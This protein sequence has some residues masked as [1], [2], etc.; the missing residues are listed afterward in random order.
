MFEWSSEYDSENA[1][2]VG[3]IIKNDGKFKSAK[4]KAYI[5]NHRC[6]ERNKE[7]LK[8][9]FGIEVEEEVV[10]VLDAD[11]FMRFA[12][13]G[14]RS[15]IPYTIINIIDD[16]G[17]KVSY[18]IRYNGNMRDGASPD[19]KRTEVKWERDHNIVSNDLVEEQEVKIEEEKKIS[20]YLNAEVGQ[21]I[22]VNVDKAIKIAEYCTNFGTTFV[23]KFISDGNVI[24]WKTG[25]YI[26][27]EIVS[28]IKGTIKEFSEYREEKQTIMT[29]C[30][31]GY[32][33]VIEERKER[34]LGQQVE[35][36]L[37]EEI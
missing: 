31:I 11:A 13:Y 1:K 23:Y 6:A 16:I 5:L 14:T 20:E 36:F 2:I 33:E 17:V 3:G 37:N 18:R 25:N 34:N 7:D 10:K 27:L 32:K 29:R 21:R 24:I 30:K 19:P 28:S 22:E 9:Y 4:Q 35:D 15:I 12:D 26:D 8:E